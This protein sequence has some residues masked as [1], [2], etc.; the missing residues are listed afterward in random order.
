[1]SLKREIKKVSKLVNDKGYIPILEGDKIL[2]VMNR[3]TGNTY[4]PKNELIVLQ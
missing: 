1:M 3:L 4:Y 2:F